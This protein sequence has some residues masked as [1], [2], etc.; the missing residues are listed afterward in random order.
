MQSFVLLVAVNSA[1]DPDVDPS[2]VEVVGLMVCGVE[3]RAGRGPVSVEARATEWYDSAG[4][5]KIASARAGPARV[6]R[7][8]WSPFGQ[9]SRLAERDPL[10]MTSRDYGHVLGIRQWPSWHLSFDAKLKRDLVKEREGFG[11]I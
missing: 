3:G 5:G 4:F 11:Q 6:Y 1:A 8:R 10:C 2:V 9:K 7:L